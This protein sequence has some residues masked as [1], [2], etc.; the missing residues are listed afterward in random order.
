M[1]TITWGNQNPRLEHGVSAGV[2]YVGSSKGVAWNGIIG[3]TISP[4][5]GT[6]IGSYIDGVKYQNHPTGEELSGTIAAMFSPEEFDPC[7][8]YDDFS[9][10]VITPYGRREEFGLCF[11]SNLDEGYRLHLVYNATATPATR[12]ART[13]TPSPN[14]DALAWSF[15]TRAEPLDGYSPVS[16]IIVDSTR[17]DPNRLEVLED[18]LYGSDLYDPRLPSPEEIVRIFV[19]E[20]ALFMIIDHGDGSFSAIGPDSMVTELQQGEFQLNS[21]TVEVDEHGEFYVAASYSE[22]GGP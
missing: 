8:G 9:E 3:I 6:P 13:L 19:G 20:D 12:T 4:S 16:Y 14:V 10:G 1:S 5:G 18:L 22:P 21:P 7:D 17:V 2:L 11:R 15:T